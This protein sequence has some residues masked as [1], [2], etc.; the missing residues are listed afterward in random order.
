M[1]KLKSLF[2]LCWQ[3]LT[4]LF[5]TKISKKGSIEEKLRRDGIVFIPDF[6]SPDKCDSIKSFLLRSLENNQDG[7]KLRKRNKENPEGTDH[8]MIDMVVNPKLIEAEIMKLFDRV[9]SKIAIATNLETY[10]TRINAYINRGVINTRGYHMDNI[11]PTLF[12]AFVYLT[13]VESTDHGPYA[14]IKGTHQ[15]SKWPY[16]NL[17][18]N[19]F[20]KTPI[21]DMAL[22]P[23]KREVVA[24]AKKGTL[25]IS[26]Q[27]G[28][29]RGVPQKKG[30]ER[31]LLL[32]SYI[33]LHKRSY[34]GPS[35]K[36]EI[37]S[38]FRKWSPEII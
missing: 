16:I 36:R 10:H 9:G 26:S 33:S 15:L 18:A 12:K 4:N 28:I 35:V 32:F 20:S 30:N 22:F 5:S 7:I 3:D 24:L 31:F 23:K 1:R 37:E 19:I 29:H 13:D 38:A 34:L 17:L 11:H 6:L 21:T 8:G 2:T 27:N 14:F 25:I